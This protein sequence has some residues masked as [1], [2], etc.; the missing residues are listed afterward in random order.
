[1]A[2][3]V[4][5][6]G[7]YIPLPSSSLHSSPIPLPLRPR[8][9]ARHTEDAAATPPDVGRRH[10]LARVHGPHATPRT[11]D[12]AAPLLPGRPRQMRGHTGTV[13]SCVDTARRRG[14]QRARA[15]SSPPFP[16]YAACSVPSPGYTV[17]NRSMMRSTLCLLGSAYSI[18]M[19]ETHCFRQVH[20]WQVHSW[21]DT[22]AT[23]TLV[24]TLVCIRTYVNKCVY[25]SQTQTYT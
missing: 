15:A 7:I 10:R 19:H 16:R 21:L 25:R 11:N 1:M 3:G 18:S 6:R 5:G 17:T 22:V 12:L 23:K 24:V 20:S 2:P 4:K 14:R 8:H 13:P 9:P